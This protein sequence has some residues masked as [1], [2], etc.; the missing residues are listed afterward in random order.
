MPGPTV[1]ADDQLSWPARIAVLGSE[2]RQAL[3]GQFGTRLEVLNG[4]LRIGEVSL[5]AGPAPVV[6]LRHPSSGY[7]M[8]SIYALQGAMSAGGIS[9]PAG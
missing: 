4:L 1:V 8:Q 3:E 9:V 2:P 7:G 6:A 5:A